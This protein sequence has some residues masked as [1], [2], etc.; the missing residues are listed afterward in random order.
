MG[1]RPSRARAAREVG[2]SRT[3]PTTRATNPP[4]SGRAPP[5]SLPPAAPIKTTARTKAIRPGGRAANLL[6]RCRPSRQRRHDGDAGDGASGAGGGQVRRDEGQDQCDAD[7]LPG[8]RHH[9][10][11]VMGALHEVRSVGE[12]QPEAHN[13][14][15]KGADEAHHGAVRPNHQA[16]V[17]VGG[18]EGLEH[19]NGAEPALG[20]HGE[21]GDG[22]QADQQHAQRGQGQHDGLGVERVARGLGARRIDVRP[23]RRRDWPRARRTGR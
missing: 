4:I 8:Q 6:G 11:D 13:R 16:D 22:D 19:A 7:H 14:A 15:E 3:T 12:P 23:E 10:D 18:P 5:P 9:A 1:C 2:A 17:A 20:Q 21:A